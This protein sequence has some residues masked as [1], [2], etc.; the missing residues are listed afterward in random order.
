MYTRDANNLHEQ[1]TKEKYCV[2]HYCHDLHIRD[3][4]AGNIATVYLPGHIANIK[5]AV[6]CPT[7]TKTENSHAVYSNEH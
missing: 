3:H 6:Q 7:Q 1:R 2:K 4:R 5:G